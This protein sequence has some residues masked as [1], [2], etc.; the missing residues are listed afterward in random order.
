MVD[1]L[2]K[3]DRSRQ[4]SRIGS[5]NTS[6]ELTVRKY[7]WRAGFRYRLHDK[8]L[9]GKPD[10]VLKSRKAIIFVNGCYW[11]GHHCSRGSSPQT[12]VM[13]WSDKIFLNRERDRRN[14]SLLQLS[15]WGVFTI[16]E[17]QLR[18]K[19]RAAKALQDLALQLS[20]LE[21]SRS[22]KLS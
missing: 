2:S 10:I 1:H 14:I 3:Q 18:S 17:C 13:F 21:D 9:P 4:M 5:K 7:L 16:W 20:E 12:N 6:L 19:A 11:H 8:A 22:T 15:G